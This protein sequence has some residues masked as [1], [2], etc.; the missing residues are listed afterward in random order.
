MPRF[1][2]LEHNHPFLHWDF[3]LETGTALRTWRLASPPRRDEV[4][5][6]TPLGDHRLI[7]LDYEGPVSRER[8]S[9]RRW[10]GGT[11][12]MMRES[13]TIVIVNLHGQRIHGKATLS[14]NDAGRWTFTCRADD[15]E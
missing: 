12:E 6:A 7:Y 9:V 1:V 10:D 3:M 11:Y 13:D 5:E 8:G 4:I 2:L 15:R 14:G